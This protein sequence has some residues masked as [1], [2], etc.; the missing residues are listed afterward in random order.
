VDSSVLT[1]IPKH[2]IIY[3]IK[4]CKPE[5]IMLEFEIPKY[6]GNWS[7]KAYSNKRELENDKKE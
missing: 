2:C 5:L 4:V 1:A 3:C 6:M 7:T